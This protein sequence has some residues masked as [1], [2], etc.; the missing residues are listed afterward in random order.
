MPKARFRSLDGLRG[1]CALTVVL[2]HC[3]LLFRPGVVFCHGYLAV[4]MFYVLSGFVICAG[5]D[6]RLAAGLSA[7]RFLAARVR[8]LAPVYW[9]GLALCT[10]G[11][12]FA[13]RYLPGVQPGRIAVRALMAA[14]L[15]P[16]SGPGDFAYPVNPV[17]WTLAWELIVN[18][19]YA[20]WLRRL[21]SPVL[22]AIVALSLLAAGG[23]S[24]ADSRGWG[25][26]MTGAD[27][28]L[29]GFRCFPEYLLGVLLFRGFRKGLLAGLP[30]VTPLLPLTLWLAIAVIPQGM[31]PLLDAAVVVLACPL[32]IALLLRG[33]A[34]SPGWF[35]P[36]GAISYPLYASH[37]ALVSL[38]R[39]TPIFG[40]DRHPDAGRAGLVVLL[41][42]AVAWVLH[43]ALEAGS[44]SAALARKS[45][46]PPGPEAASCL[47]ARHSL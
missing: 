38:A 37:L 18:V 17:A 27:I 13:A 34:A 36:L 47:S 26:G 3:E 31:P 30:A 15:I 19:V 24:L 5:Y 42:L 6:E 20:K 8:R 39:H 33:D 22:A 40:L 2:Y 35:A 16:Q 9:A 14:V 4:D 25:F 45:A 43:K 28:W 7:R 41:A 1:V 46:V 11:A 10:A 12:L 29:G 21:S 23:V 32:L 44:I